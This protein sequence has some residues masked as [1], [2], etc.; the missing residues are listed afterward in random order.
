MQNIQK[1]RIVT[2]VLECKILLFI[3]DFFYGIVV[4]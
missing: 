4:K 1:K 3:L 2:S